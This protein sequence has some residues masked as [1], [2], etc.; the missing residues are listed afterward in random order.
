MKAATLKTPPYS[1]ITHQIRVSVR[2]KV[3]KKDSDPQNGVYAFGYTVKIE[4]L[5]CD[6]VQLLERHWKVTS[7]EVQIAEVVGPGVVG[8]QPVLEAGQ[9]FEYSSGTVINDPFGWMEGTYTFRANGGK[10]LQVTIPRF[11]LF[12]PLVLH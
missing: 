6:T 3:I 11:E 12:Y 7:A 2:P 1:E 9:S 4:N 10:F 8:E 5:G